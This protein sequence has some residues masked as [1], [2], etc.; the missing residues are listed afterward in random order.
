MD[1]LHSDLGN[2][3][4]TCALADVP[5]AQVLEDLRARQST[6]TEHSVRLLATTSS[7]LLSNPHRTERSRG[8]PSFARG[9]DQGQDRLRESP[10][11]TTAAT[12]GGKPVTAVMPDSEFEWQRTEVAEFLGLAFGAT[13]AMHGALVLTGAEF[14]LGSPSVLALYVPG[15]AGPSLA[16]FAVQARRSGR[17]GVR[18][19]L[20]RVR[21][22][23]VRRS[24]AAIAIGSQLAMTG[25]SA[26][27]GR[28]TVSVD[29]ALIAA[30]GYVVAAEEFGWRGWLWPRAAHRFGTRV[31]TAFVTLVWGLW[32]LP[33]FAVADSSQA[34]D[35]LLQFTAAIAA[36]GALHGH[37][38]T[39][40]Q[41]V[42]AAMLLHAVTNMTVSTFEVRSATV[43]TGVYTTVAVVAFA[44]LRGPA[45]GGSAAS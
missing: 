38:Q 10:A 8:D 15:L 44:L 34:R 18:Q 2:P 41:S 3:E 4:K 42:A 19:L 31:G 17:A 1:G 27:L 37:V 28:V 33:M 14:D 43:L 13:W 32:H 24:T 35:G 25:A 40:S 36:W 26:A 29:P 6:D 12:S 23:R 39:R 16:A 20:E 7:K 11:W 45:A 5:I 9:P 21:W 30:Q 22:R